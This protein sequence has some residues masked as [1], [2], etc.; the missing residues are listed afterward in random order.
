MRT[1][2]EIEAHYIYLTLKH[3]HWNRTHAAKSLG[4]TVRCVRYK[5]PE[6]RKAGYKIPEV[7]RKKF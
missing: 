6:L 2:A 4:I 7:F 5:I 3:F 1:L